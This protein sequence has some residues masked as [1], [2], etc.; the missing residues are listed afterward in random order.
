MPVGTPGFN[1]ESAEV[2]PR[3]PRK[4]ENILFFYYALLIARISGV[5]QQIFF[6]VSS[7][8]SA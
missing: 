4:P 1:P 8:S 7:A 2:T 6:L 3:T 5:N